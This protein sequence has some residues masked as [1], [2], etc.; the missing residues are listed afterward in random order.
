MLDVRRLSCL[1][2]PL[3]LALAAGCAPMGAK[4]GRVDVTSDPAGADVYAMGSKVGVTPLTLDQDVIFPLTYPSEKQALYGVV[5]L[6]KAGCGDARQSV[7]TRALARGIHVKL[8]CGAAARAE[9]PTP[10]QAQPS[11]APAPVNAHVPPTPVAKE[12]PGIEPRLRQVQD[13]R[14]KGL[15]TEQEAREIRRRILDEL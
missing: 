3:T 13:L 12:K 6:R 9:T 11:P 4:P 5:E 14:D 15:I 2:A 1:L 7:S 10:R 8:D